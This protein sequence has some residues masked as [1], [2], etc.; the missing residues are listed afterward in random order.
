[1][2]SEPTTSEAHLTRANQLSTR[3]S[4]G[5][6][7]T[8][9]SSTSL[10]G[11]VS[12]PR[13]KRPTD[14]SLPPSNSDDDHLEGQEN[15]HDVGYTKEPTLFS[16]L[17]NLS[18]N[19]SRG[20]RKQL[21]K[22][23]HNTSRAGHQQSL[24]PI[25]TTRSQSHHC[26]NPKPSSSRSI[27]S[28]AATN[29]TGDNTSDIRSGGSS[30]ASETCIQPKPISANK[31]PTISSHRSHKP[32]QKIHI[33]HARKVIK[34]NPRF[35]VSPHSP[36]HSYPSSLNVGHGRA[37]PNI[38]STTHTHVNILSKPTTSWIPRLA[39]RTNK[40]SNSTRQRCKVQRTSS[41]NC[42]TTSVRSTTPAQNIL[43]GFLSNSNS[44]NSR[45]TSPTDRKYNCAL[46][47]LNFGDGM[48]SVL[49]DT[50]IG[51]MDVNDV[52]C[53][54]KQE[55]PEVAGKY[56]SLK[57]RVA[58]GSAKG[59][60]K[61]NAVVDS[62]LGIR[63]VIDISYACAA[64]ENLVVRN[65]ISE[66]LSVPLPLPAPS[67]D[68]SSHHKPYFPP[69][70][71]NTNPFLSSFNAGTAVDGAN[72]DPDEDDDMA[73]IPF[74]I[75]PSKHTV[76]ITF[77]DM[78][79][80]K[81]KHKAGGLSPAVNG[82]ERVSSNG[83]STRHVSF[84]AYRTEKVARERSL[85]ESTESTVLHPPATA[86][87]DKAGNASP[88]QPLTHSTSSKPSGLPP[89][90]PSPL[91]SFPQDIN[92]S[93]A[94]R[95]VESVR[96]EMA[97][98]TGSFSPT[99]NQQAPAQ[100]SRFQ[101][102]GTRTTLRKDAWGCVH[103]GPAE[104]ELSIRFPQTPHY[105][106]WDLED[107]DG[108]FVTVPAL[109]CLMAK[110]HL[111]W[112]SSPLAIP[113]ISLL[114]IRCDAVA[115]AAPS[116]SSSRAHKRPRRF[117]PLHD[118]QLDNFSITYSGI[119]TGTEMPD[120][121][122]HPGGNSPYRP[123]VRLP[124]PSGVNAG[125]AFTF[126]RD[127][128]PMGYSPPRGEIPG[129]SIMIEKWMRAYAQPGVEGIKEHRRRNNADNRRPSTTP[130]I[131]D[132][133]NPATTSMTNINSSTSNPFLPPLHSPNGLNPRALALLSQSL[134]NANAQARNPDPR[135]ILT[136]SHALNGW[137]L[138]VWIPIPTRLF[139]K[140]ETKK[141]RVSARVWIAGDNQ[142]EGDEDSE[143]SD[144]GYGPLSASSMASVSDRAPFSPF[145]ERSGQSV[146][147]DPHSPLSSRFSYGHGY[148]VAPSSG[149]GG[150]RSRRP[151]DALPLVADADMSISVLRAWREMQ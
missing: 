110:P 11:L 82:P 86:Q 21:P 98:Q 66:P 7:T 105:E 141:F 19:N 1:M 88:P 85:F 25:S 128:P 40:I 129:E 57:N 42:D 2:E 44:H 52:G 146:Q 143:D 90:L 109:L 80:K 68:S 145:D 115:P 9:R 39:S 27:E 69:P 71:V 148:D 37:A 133:K 51:Y 91:R 24:L 32:S 18:N 54:T 137:Y 59:H 150:K 5:Y 100:P 94:Q 14:I 136:P 60:A 139:R 22:E 106:A 116:A 41:T 124:S 49:H 28:T 79:I 135:P 104:C 43:P 64:S 132:I 126:K 125:R 16:N 89:P 87:S 36:R 113:D 63:D 78:S 61:E 55:K 127:L 121:L 151:S 114:D 140:S 67:S 17:T 31:S 149:M 30:T 123:V 48:P 119:H 20:K 101:P 92:T 84:A 58:N 144:G 38:L 97:G 46:N 15:R 131:I 118:P 99:F 29:V 35:A 6:L 50:S 8:L 65:D 76:K 47:E 120:R 73:D 75:S 45:P 112:G 117:G 77:E 147:P 96:R 122:G 83:A 33:S 12:R 74:S 130:P 72:V 26:L 107:D 23:F 134:S 95:L 4:R 102:A 108:L 13:K 142:D 103:L 111:S 62:T 10:Q 93:P 34:T 70:K 56:G 53:S 81:A 138:K 3:R